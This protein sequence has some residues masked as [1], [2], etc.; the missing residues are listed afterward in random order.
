MLAGAGSPLLVSRPAGQPCCMHSLL[1]RQCCRYAG[2]DRCRIQ[3]QSYLYERGITT[4]ATLVDLPRDTSSMGHIPQQQARVAVFSAARYVCI[5]ILVPW[6]QTKN[7]VT[8][9]LVPACTQVLGFLQAPLKEN[10]P[11]STFIEA[12]RRIAAAL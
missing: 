5:S 10:F 3:S 1:G 9:D 8:Q 4:R 2:W 7:L 11:D 6:H 12:R